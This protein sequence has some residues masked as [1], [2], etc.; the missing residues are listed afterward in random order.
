MGAYMPTSRMLCSLALRAMITNLHGPHHRKG[1]IAI[2]EGQ[3]PP[4]LAF[5]AVRYCSPLKDMSGQI[6][7]FKMPVLTDK[8]RG[9]QLA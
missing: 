7:A 9:E 5:G 4:S 3:R 8:G 1:M 6:G 2:S